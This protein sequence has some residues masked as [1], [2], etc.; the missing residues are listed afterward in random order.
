MSSLFPTMSS[1]AVETEAV[2]TADE[3]KYDEKSLRKAIWFRLQVSTVPQPGG[4]VISPTVMNSLMGAIAAGFTP[5]ACQKIA[6]SGALGTCCRKPATI[7][8]INSEGRIHNHCSGF[9]CAGKLIEGLNSETGTVTVYSATVSKIVANATLAESVKKYTA[10]VYTA[11]VYTAAVPCAESGDT[12][13][14]PCA[15]SSVAYDHPIFPK[16][17]EL[18]DAC[19]RALCNRD[20]A[21][22][23]MASESYAEVCSI[24]NIRLLDVVCSNPGICTP[25][26][27]LAMG[28]F[29]LEGDDGRKCVLVSNERMWYILY[30]YWWH[31]QSLDGLEVD[32]QCLC[33]CC[34]QNPAEVHSVH[35]PYA[36]WAFMC[37]GCDEECAKLGGD[38][39]RLSQGFPT[40]FK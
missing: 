24:L 16:N 13:A 11:A 2:S 20:W 32:E 40:L 1:L 7:I 4:G 22:Q 5:G 29:L 33:T 37:L 14:D 10:A 35:G 36:Q 25:D 3:Q 17:A 8:Q 30:S 21:Q 6:W 31:N 15:E 28:G 26:D 19:A 27:E 9:R 18:E 12:G 39:L 38:P 23:V 34:W